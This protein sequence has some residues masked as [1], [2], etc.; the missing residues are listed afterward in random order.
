MN[1][2]ILLP[3]DIAVFPCLLWSFLKNFLVNV[4]YLQKSRLTSVEVIF[5]GIYSWAFNICIEISLLQ[6]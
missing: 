1:S 2:R 5:H 4:I 3:N 6:V